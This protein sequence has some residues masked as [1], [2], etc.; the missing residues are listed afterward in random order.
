MG[1]RWGCWSLHQVSLNIQGSAWA[2][3]QGTR[4]LSKAGGG[5]QRGT[6]SCCIWGS[7]GFSEP[8][9]DVLGSSG[10]EL[11][12]ADRSGSQ[13]R[14]YLVVGSCLPSSPSNQLFGPTRRG[15]RF[16]QAS[17]G[18]A[19]HW[20]ILNRTAEAAYSLGWEGCVF[21]SFPG[22]SLFVGGGAC[23]LVVESKDPWNKSLP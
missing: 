11:I 23:I 22:P 6:G 16:T 2:P 8:L 21:F 15:Y 1:G 7:L 4:G 12:R 9:V 19:M 10:Q 20:W 3:G 5:G 18:P 17:P 13:S 14:A